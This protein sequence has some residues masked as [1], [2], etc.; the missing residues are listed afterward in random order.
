[1]T[2][3]YRVAAQMYGFRDFTKTP[4]DMVS[5]MRK[6]KAMGYDY[7]QVSGFGPIEAADLKK[8]CDD[9]G[10]QPIG[11]H[12]GINVFRADE[13]KVIADCRAWG[14]EYVAIPG[15]IR[16]DY[17]TL[18]DWG[19]L[20]HEMDRYAERFS[21]EGIVVQYHNHAW[22]FEKLGIKDGA[23]G[24][25]IYD[26]LWETT[27][28]LQAEPDFG[29]IARGGYNPVLWAEKLTGRIDQVHLKDWGIVDNLPEFRAIGE[30]SLDHP[31]I[32]KACKASGTKDFIV[33]QDSCK[34]TQDPFLSYAISRRNLLEM[35]L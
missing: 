30:G 25:S 35:G 34:V 6:V 3:K 19:R 28:Q 18:A 33:E 24:Q 15:L 16:T 12:V 23:G 10:V 8:I 11:A 14:V 17:K 9:A 22:E 7:L 20:F 21:K 27:K 32:I 1:M 29:W 13:A 31:A 4:K 5:T 2:G 26:L